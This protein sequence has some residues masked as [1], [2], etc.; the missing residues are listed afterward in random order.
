MRVKK[1]RA[2][3]RNNRSS[4]K[5]YGSGI[6]KLTNN[7]WSRILHEAEHNIA[8]SDKACVGD[9][10]G[11]CVDSIAWIAEVGVCA[12]DEILLDGLE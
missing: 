9:S 6:I 1:M 12:G 3:E 2:K 10:D 4:K 7:A 5:K 11:D 8:S